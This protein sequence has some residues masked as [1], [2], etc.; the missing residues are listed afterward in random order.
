MERLEIELS[1]IVFCPFNEID[2]NP[3]DSIRLCLLE[4]RSCD[5][6]KHVPSLPSVFT[7][8]RF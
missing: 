6:V 3:M 8:F 5:V 2:C 7:L 4:Q 1:S